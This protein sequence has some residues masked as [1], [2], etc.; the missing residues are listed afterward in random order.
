MAGRPRL[1]WAGLGFG[2]AA[3]AASWNPAAAPFGLAVGLGAAL[4]AVRAL[5][6]GPRRR[7]A[8]AGLAAAL[9]AVAVSALVLALTA[10]VGRQ[11]GQTTLVPQATP[12]E[13]GQALDEAAARTREARERARAE[14]E[15]LGPDPKPPAGPGPAKTPSN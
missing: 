9:A 14:L 13:V 5:R 10:G 1:S 3:L 7:V 15:R 12:A 8:A 4:V 2:L 11:A 6:A